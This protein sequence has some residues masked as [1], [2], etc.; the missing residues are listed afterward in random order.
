MNK[1]KI[2][3]IVIGLGV[4]ILAAAIYFFASSTLSAKLQGEK[5]TTFTPSTSIPPVGGQASNQLTVDKPEDH[6]STTISPVTVTGSTV[7]GA[8]I[9]LFGNADEKIASA[10]AQGKFSVDIKLEDGE[11]EISVTAL[12]SLENVLVVKRNVTLEII[13]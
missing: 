12:D 2:I 1:E 9:I 6:S 11:N 10:D 8:K 4:G 13:Q 3:T 5:K 7:A